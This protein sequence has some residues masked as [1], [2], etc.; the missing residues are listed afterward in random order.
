MKLPSPS[1]S[2]HDAL[3]PYYYESAPA[4]RLQR[5]PFLY[6]KNIKLVS[7]DITD[8]GPG[9]PWKTYLLSNIN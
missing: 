6:P 9:L 1:C 7:A 3:Y 4:A 2:I 5:A 8:K